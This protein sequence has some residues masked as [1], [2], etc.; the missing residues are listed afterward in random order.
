MAAIAYL[1]RLDGK[2]DEE[3]EEFCDLAKTYNLSEIEIPEALHNRSESEVLSLVRQLQYPRFA[4][5]LIREMFYFGYADGDLSDS[6]IMFISK[7]GLTLN[8]PI[9]KMEQISS[10]VIRGIELEEEGV[11]IFS[12]YS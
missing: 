3:N 8:I 1:G 9:E 12:D 7:V 6:K 5:I 4:L 2:L 10:W 11:E